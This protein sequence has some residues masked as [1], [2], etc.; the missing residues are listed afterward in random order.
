MPEP[1]LFAWSG[2]KDSALALQALRQNPDLEVV[3]LLS[4]FIEADSAD[5]VGERLIMHR[6]PRTL[7]ERQAEAVGLPLYP[8]IL[9]SVPSNT[10]YEARTGA[11]LA[12]FQAIGVQSV[13]HGDLFLEDIRQYRDGNLARIGMKGMYPV[14]GQDTRSLAQRFVA[15]GFRA[16]VV[17]VDTTQLD[18]SFAGRIIDEDF[19]RDLPWHVDPCGENG[20]FHTFVYD[21][22]I[23]TAPISITAGAPYL[24]DDRFQYCDIV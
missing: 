21:A 10:E 6:V 4:N 12:H 9:P 24:R 3:A 19:L 15:E 1:I 17:C 16:I 18:A 2:G 11:A 20:E 23:F 5:S 13:A 7:I 8:V 14:W 22:P